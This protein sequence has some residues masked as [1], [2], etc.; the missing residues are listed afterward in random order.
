MVE[1]IAIIGITILLPVITGK[2]KRTRKAYAPANN[3]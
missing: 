2:S 3:K 1:L